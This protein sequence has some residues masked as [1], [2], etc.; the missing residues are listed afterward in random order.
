[1][2][3]LEI[4]LKCR[5]WSN[6]SLV[7]AWD[8]EFLTNSQCSL[9]LLVPGPDFFFCLPFPGGSAGKESACNARDLGLMPGLGRSPGE[10]ND[11]PPQYSGLEYSLDLQSIGSQRVRHDWVTFTFTV[12]RTVGLAWIHCWTW[13]WVVEWWVDHEVEFHSSLFSRGV[14]SNFI[15]GIYSCFFPGGHRKAVPPNRLTFLP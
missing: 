7:R 13:F 3:Y 12:L 6:M 14:L 11:Y 8:S 15:R 10:G 1:M 4:L 9:K 5:F 2:N